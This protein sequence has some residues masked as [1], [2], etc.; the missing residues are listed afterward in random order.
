MRYVSRTCPACSSQR[1]FLLSSTL[2]YQRG[3]HSTT[4]RS[5]ERSRTT[6][7]RNQANFQGSCLPVM[8][9]AKT[10]G[11]WGYGYGRTLKAHRHSNTTNSSEMRAEVRTGWINSKVPAPGRESKGLQ[12]TEK[13][14]YEETVRNCSQ[15][16]SENEW[17]TS[18]LP[19]STGSRIMS[20][21]T[22][23][24]PSLRAGPAGHSVTAL[25]GR[26]KW[27]G[28]RMKCA[29]LCSYTLVMLLD[30]CWPDLLA[31]TR[32]GTH[33]FWWSAWGYTRAGKGYHSLIPPSHAAWGTRDIT[34]SKQ[35]GKKITAIHFRSVPSSLKRST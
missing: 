25:P 19:A 13:G 18:K 6:V 2:F 22:C 3:N 23:H 11:G 27:V 1:G 7:N 32:G 21:L 35:Q 34:S 20:L 30:L 29:L 33:R 17:H 9:T 24:S 28:R 26:I 8:V 4:G 16:L 14:P 5:S 10:G 31:L 15:N 12:K